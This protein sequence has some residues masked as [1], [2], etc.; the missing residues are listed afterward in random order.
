MLLLLMLLF[1]VKTVPYPPCDPKVEKCVVVLAPDPDCKKAPC[2][3]IPVTTQPI[4]APS[5]TK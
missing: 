2:K 1:Q 4:Q 3:M 5:R